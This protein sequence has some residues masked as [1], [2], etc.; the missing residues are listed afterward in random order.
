MKKYINRYF[1]YKH[2][3]TRAKK[4]SDLDTGIQ[5]LTIILAFSGIYLVVKTFKLKRKID[6]TTLRARAFLNDSFLMDVWS[7]LILACLFFIIHASV[8]LNGIFMLVSIEPI[9][10]VIIKE[11]T[12]MGVLVCVLLQVYKWFRLVYVA[13]FER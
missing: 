9:I 13:K 1:Y 6:Y 10:E 2:P 4:M 8:E 7:L 3:I 5:I 12:E 11:G